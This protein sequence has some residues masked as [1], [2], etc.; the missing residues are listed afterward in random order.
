MKRVYRGKVISVEQDG[1]LLI[2]DNR[3]QRHRIVS[4]DISI[5]KLPENR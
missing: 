5:K 4:G 1:A 3:G 2:V